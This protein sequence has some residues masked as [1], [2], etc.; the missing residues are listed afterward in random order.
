MIAS[1]VCIGHGSVRLNA[2]VLVIGVGLLVAYAWRPGC[3]TPG[4]GNQEPDSD[5]QDQTVQHARIV[6]ADA[7]SDH[8]T[9]VPRRA[10][11]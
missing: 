3:R 10:P 5:H 8:A 9:M 4:V 11:D 6:D 1:S 7:R 2:L